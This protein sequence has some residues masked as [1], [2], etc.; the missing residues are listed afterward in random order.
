MLIFRKSLLTYKIMEYCVL[1]VTFRD[2][3]LCVK[4][5]QFSRVFKRVF[6]KTQKEQNTAKGLKK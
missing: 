3:I 6:H 1:G 5:S 2:G 4:N